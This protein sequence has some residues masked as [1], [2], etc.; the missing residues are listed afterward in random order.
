VVAGRPAQPV[1]HGCSASPSGRRAVGGMPSPSAKAFPADPQELAPRPARAA[2]HPPRAAG[3]ARRLH[4]RLQHPAPAP[5]PAAP[6]HPR[7]LVEA[8]GEWQVGERRYL[9]EG[10]YGLLAT[11]AKHVDRRMVKII[12]TTTRDITERPWPGSLPGARPR[13]VQA[14]TRSCLPPFADGGKWP[15]ADFGVMGRRWSAGGIAEMWLV[16][17]G[18]SAGGGVPAWRPR[19]R[20]PGDGAAAGAGWEGLFGRGMAGPVAAQAVA[21]RGAGRRTPRS[22]RR[23][24]RAATARRRRSVPRTPCPLQ[25]RPVPCRSLSREPAVA[26]PGQ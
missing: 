6:G 13:L 18:V 16:M 8:H 12:Y 5:L 25:G 7:H 23:T 10:S 1:H 24:P 11:P 22:G 9:S 14:A 21:R 20:R 2:C 3:P 26:L 4:R 17:T 19:S 15:P